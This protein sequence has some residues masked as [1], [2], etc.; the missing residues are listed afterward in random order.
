MR[1]PAGPRNLPGPLLK[2]YSKLMFLGT[3]FAAAMH[4]RTTS[5]TANIFV[6]Q[7]M[8][9][10]ARL[11][12]LFTVNTPSPAHTPREYYQHTHLVSRFDSALCVCNALPAA[13]SFQQQGLES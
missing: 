10:L 12:G 9:L 4:Q 1:L 7:N 13:V 2:L 6:P 3:I 5:P 8:H 11:V